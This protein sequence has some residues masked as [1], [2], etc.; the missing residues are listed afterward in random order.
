MEI[1]LQDG[2]H[3]DDQDQDN[4]EEPMVLTSA[5]VLL[6]LEH[7]WMNE[8]MSPDVL[9]PL[10]QEKDAML[11]QIKVMERNV[12]TLDKKDVR[13]DIHKLELE[14]IKYI[15]VSYMRTRFFKVQRMSFALYEAEM[16]RPRGEES[17][18]F[19]EEFTFLKNL[20][21][22]TADYLK[23]TLISKMPPILQK[24]EIKK[25]RVLPQMDAFVFFRVVENQTVEVGI[26]IDE[27]VTIDLEEGDLHFMRYEAVSHL[28]AGGA[29]QLI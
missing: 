23:E 11:G 22:R 12:I 19:K 7:G 10:E 3:V 24:F 17:V 9:P 2:D 27:F 13:T 16:K 18:L 29:V 1:S 26:S 15:V 4:D 20:A 6:R 25:F 28:V 5:E 8:K 14:R 21:T